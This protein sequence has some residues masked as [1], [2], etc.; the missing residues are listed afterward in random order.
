METVLQRQP[1]PPL[2]HVR[3]PV[4][5]KVAG[6]EFLPLE[7]GAGCPDEEAAADDQ[8][9]GVWCARMVD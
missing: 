3:E 4:A 9:G 6:R 7:D 1:G 5:A 2:S 8:L